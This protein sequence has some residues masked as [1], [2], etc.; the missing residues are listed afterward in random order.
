MISKEY[1]VEYC[2]NILSS[3]F[4]T[5]AEEITSALYHRCEIKY[6]RWP[7]DKLSKE[8]NFNAEYLTSLPKISSY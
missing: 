2:R 7:V 1:C 4:K 3:E 6:Q 5:M 8:R